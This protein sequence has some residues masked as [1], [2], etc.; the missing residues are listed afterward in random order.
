MAVATD[1]A[2]VQFRLTITI[3]GA[4]A[5]TAR[6]HFLYSFLDYMKGR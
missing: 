4:F 1:E 6:L 5:I 2:S 3:F